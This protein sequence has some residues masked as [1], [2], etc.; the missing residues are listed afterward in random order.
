MSQ[1]IPK[2]VQ[3]ALRD[4]IDPELGYSI[5]DRSLV[6]GVEIKE[7]AINVGMTMTT[8]GCLRR[9]RQEAA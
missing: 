6:Y 1:R 2:I 5:A 3:K 4:V 9:Y 8:P 7:R